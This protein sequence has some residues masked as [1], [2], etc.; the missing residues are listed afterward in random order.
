MGIGTGAVADVISYGW[1]TDDWLA[2]RLE[3]L[4]KLDND[5]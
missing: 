1:F 4:K 2:R 3:T 5:N